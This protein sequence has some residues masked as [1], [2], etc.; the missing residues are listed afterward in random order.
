ML[1]ILEITLRNSVT[2]CIGPVVQ[3]IPHYPD[4]L[5]PGTGSLIIQILIGSLVGGIFL[6]KVIGGKVRAFFGRL[7]SRN[8]KVDQ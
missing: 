4:Y 1:E 2:L 6:L 3:Q 7:F 5:D 8:K